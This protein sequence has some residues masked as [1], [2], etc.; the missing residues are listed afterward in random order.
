MA[1]ERIPRALLLVLGGI[2]AASTGCASYGPHL[3]PW[4]YP[5]PV[6]P[7][8]MKKQEDKFWNHERYD[9]M[10]ILGPLVAGAPHVGI[11]EPSDDEVMRALEEI[12]RVQGGLPF[13]YEIQRNNVQI[14]KEKIADFVDPPR[15]YP[16]VGP[17]QLHHVR[18]KCTVFYTRVI[19]PGWPLP[20]HMVD[21]TEEVIY[22]D[23][24]HLHMVGAEPPISS[25]IAAVAEVPA[26]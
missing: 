8:F 11:D 23:H 13:L 14:V 10:P 19:R 25:S 17:A 12:D 21:E 9:K 20:Q 18:W 7:Y 2:V 1:S 15:V 16:L 6:S 4:A 22:I 5:I 26:T 24:D 3:G